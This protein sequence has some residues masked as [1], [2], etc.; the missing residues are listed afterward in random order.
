M[1]EVDQ[2]VFFAFLRI[3]DVVRVYLTGI[4]VT[5]SS[6]SKRQIPLF[7]L[8]RLQFLQFQKILVLHFIHQFFVLL[9]KPLDAR[10][11]VVLDQAPTQVV[12]FVFDH[13]FVFAALERI[14][15]K[16]RDLLQTLHVASKEM[17]DVGDLDQ[18]LVSNPH[19]FPSVCHH[20]LVHLVFD[21]AV[22]VWLI[23]FRSNRCLC[24]QHNLIELS[25]HQVR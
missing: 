10:H 13:G 18:D 25:L 2:L 17:L 5:V 21:L 20:V 22:Q 16:V 14:K 1:F 23:G 6:Q 3:E 8:Y 9:G 7:E 15:I 11:E 12:D 19:G 24:L 4:I